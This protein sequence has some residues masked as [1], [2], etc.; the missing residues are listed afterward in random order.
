MQEKQSQ[1]NQRHTNNEGKATQESPS[2]S[3]TDHNQ[4][5]Q[6]TQTG[7][8]ANNK[9][10]G[11]DSMLPIPTNPNNLI[12]NGTAEAEGGMDGGCQES[13]INMQEKGSKGGNLP[14]VMHEGTNLDPRTDFRA[15]AT[16]T[17]QPH[18]HVQQQVQ[19][20]AHSG[21]GKLRSTDNNK[22][23]QHERAGPANKQ[24]NGAMAK[25][26]G[27]KAST[28]NQGN[29]PK[30]KN[31]PSKKR[32]DAEKKR[33]SIQQDNT[34]QGKQQKEGEVCKK[35]IMV[36]EHLGMDITPL[37]TQYMNPPINVPP[38]DRSANCQ[39]NTGPIIDEYAVDNSE[40]EPDVD[41]Q[42]LKDPDEDDETSELLIRAFS[43][44]PDKDFTEEIQQVANSQGLSPRGLHH[45]RFKFQV[46]DINT[47]TAGRPN[48]RLFTSP[49]SQ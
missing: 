29:T 7:S 40:D 17:A 5:E 33:Q 42:S 18:Q 19:Q 3:K 15:T 22:E 8:Q 46:Q 6:I 1:D 31:K 4:K 41:N 48:T 13:H 38:D 35:F 47:V 49:S 45:E 44:H 26:M 32:R 23:K 16:T 2:K 27:A 39:M 28:S 20:Q 24:N 43:P 12:F 14:H 25:D 37:Q 36:D 10:T 34:Q 11:I 30:S 9:S 21:P